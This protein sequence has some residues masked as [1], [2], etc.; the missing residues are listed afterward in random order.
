VR[1]E[2]GRSTGSEAQ[3]PWPAGLHAGSSSSSR[4][5]GVDN[6]YIMLIVSGDGGWM[7]C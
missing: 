4:D 2:G 1:G 7:L 6:E 5:L 3:P